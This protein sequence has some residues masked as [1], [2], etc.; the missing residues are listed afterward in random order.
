MEIILDPIDIPGKISYRIAGATLVVNIDKSG[1]T[2]TIIPDDAFNHSFELKNIDTGDESVTQQLSVV[3]EPT[4]KYGD[5]K[6]T[7]NF[8]LGMMQ[9]KYGALLYTNYDKQE[10]ILQFRAY[11]L[12]ESEHAYSCVVDGLDIIY[13]STSMEDAINRATAC[14]KA[15]LRHFKLDIFAHE[16]ISTQDEDGHIW[17]KSLTDS[18]IKNSPNAIVK[19]YSITYP[20][21]WLIKQ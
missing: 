17:F 4:N 21:P 8:V 2:Y 16:Y 10:V 3:V 5:F 13:S 15:S 18:P 14:V 12:K 19:E 7:S 1:Y 11:I 6:L 9:N 20:A